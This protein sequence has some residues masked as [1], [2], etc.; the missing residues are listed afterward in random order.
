MGASIS[1]LTAAGPQQGRLFVGSTGTVP[2]RAPKKTH[3]D[4]WDI[5]PWRGNWRRSYPG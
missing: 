5:D 4:P 3:T 1:L 2:H